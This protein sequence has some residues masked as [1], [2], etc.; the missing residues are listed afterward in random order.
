MSHYRGSGGAEIGCGMMI[1]LAFVMLLGFM[2]A[3][4]AGAWLL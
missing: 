1:V 3:L 2:I 4:L